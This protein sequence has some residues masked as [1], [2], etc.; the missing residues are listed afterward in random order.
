[1]NLDNSDEDVWSAAIPNQENGS[2]IHYY[3]EAIANS[4]KTVVRPLPAPEGYFSFSIEEMNTSVT[5]LEFTS[6]RLNTIYPNPSNSISFIE[7]DALGIEEIKIS[8]VNLLGERNSLIYQGTTRP[9]T[10][11]Y[12]FDLDDIPAGTYWIELNSDKIQT[13]QY[14]KFIKI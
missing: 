1:M 3:I 6:L 7:V 14:L 12:K 9:G 8:L 11:T 2:H 13:S 4:G 5:D 10:N